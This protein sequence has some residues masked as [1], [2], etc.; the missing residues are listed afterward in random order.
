MGS[1]RLDCYRSIG[2]IRI[3]SIPFA[4][5]SFR[6]IDTLLESDSFFIFGLYGLGFL[7]TTFCFPGPLTETRYGPPIIDIGQ[8]PSC[9]SETA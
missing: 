9:T 3:E 4:A 6:C 2:F 7:W 5:N 1:Q 8:K